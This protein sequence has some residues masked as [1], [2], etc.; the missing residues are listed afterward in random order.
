MATMPRPPLP[1][2]PGP[3]APAPPGPGGMP[4]PPGMPGAGPPTPMGNP[5]MALMGNLAGNVPGGDPGAALRSL[6][7][8]PG[9]DNVEV[10]IRR[11]QDAIG[12]AMAQVHQRS[13][14]VAKELAS[15]L[16][17]LKQAMQKLQT[18][19]REEMPRPPAGLGMAPQMG[20]A[21]PGPAPMPPAF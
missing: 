6:Q 17:N 2:P 15:A 4:G 8:T 10:A 14:E 19:P 3:G 13:P 20:G 5:L 1:M 16:M 7:A 21:P 18:L 11:G 9:P 12:F